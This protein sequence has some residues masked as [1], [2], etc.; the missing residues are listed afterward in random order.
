MERPIARPFQP[1]GK[2]TRYDG[3]SSDTL[4]VDVYQHWLEP[5]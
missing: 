3:N 2:R 4:L 5:A 1:I